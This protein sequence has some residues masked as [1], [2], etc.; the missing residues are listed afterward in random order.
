M[1]SPENAFLPFMVN[2]AETFIV[3][4]VV[5]AYT[6]RPAREPADKPNATV[7]AF[8]RTQDQTAPEKS[9]MMLL[10]EQE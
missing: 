9:S 8:V 7:K 2:Y 4:A 10:Q 3:P 6:I 5:E 1:E